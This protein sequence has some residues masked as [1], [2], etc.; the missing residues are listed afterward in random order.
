MKITKSQLKRIIKEELLKEYGGVAGNFGGVAGNL[1]AVREPLAPLENEPDSEVQRQA[2]EFFAN[3][4]ITEKVVR[5]LINNIAIPDLIS[6]MEKVPKIDT[7]EEEE[8][9]Q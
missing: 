3:L 5:V 9:T 2:A 1:A 7:A 6:V 8:E 4:E